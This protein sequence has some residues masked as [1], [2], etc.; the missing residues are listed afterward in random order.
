MLIARTLNPTR[1]FPPD[2]TS[3]IRFRFARLF[4]DAL[5]RI[6][7]DLGVDVEDLDFGSLTFHQGEEVLIQK[8]FDGGSVELSSVLGKR[9]RGAVN[10]PSVCVVFPVDDAGL[11]QMPCGKGQHY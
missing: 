8:E 9:G 7:A 2:T 11:K 3:Y 10:I 5:S 6:A 1:R 4:Q